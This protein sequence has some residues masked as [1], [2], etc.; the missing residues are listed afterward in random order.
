MNTNKLRTVEIYALAIS[1]IVTVWAMLKV[2][3]WQIDLAAIAVICWAI[4]PYVIL[5]SA[6]VLL[7]KFTSLPKIW[8]VSCVTSIL[9]LVFTL[10]FYVGTAG[11]DSSTY[12]LI[13]IFVPIWLYIGGLTLLIL[14]SLVA[15]LSEQIGKRNIK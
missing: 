10:L 9:M 3:A 12:A 14:G 4:S 2:A 8:L 5:F 13:F 7:S 11:D 15:W 1:T 6:T